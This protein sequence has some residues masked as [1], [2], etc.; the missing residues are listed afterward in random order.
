MRLYYFPL[1]LVLALAA[2]ILVKLRLH[3]VAVRPAPNTTNVSGPAPTSLDE[4]LLSKAGRELIR[5]PLLVNSNGFLR[6][7]PD[8]R[9]YLDTH[10]ELR[11]QISEQAK[12]AFR[13]SVKFAGAEGPAAE[14]SDNE[15]TAR[16]IEKSKSD[17][18]AKSEDGEF[19]SFLRDHD[20]VANELRSNPRLVSD[21][22][23]LDKHP[24][25][26]DFLASHPVL[27]GKIKTDP[28]VMA[29]INV[30]PD[31]LDSATNRASE[32]TEFLEHHPDV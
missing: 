2:G 13:T 9:S 1:L 31:Y 11:G 14:E 7:H 12:L 20:D 6:D 5:H 30:P 23:Y 32:I 27:A 4:I 15:A 29:S 24:A 10:P 18:W 16:E 3:P 17:E 21:Q 8:V 28:H 26:G 25:L 19:A 22:G